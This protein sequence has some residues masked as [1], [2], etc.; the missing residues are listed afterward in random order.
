MDNG[1][2]LTEF[3]SV[4]HPCGESVTIVH[5]ILVLC[6]VASRQSGPHWSQSSCI[7]HL[8]DMKGWPPCAF[9]HGACQSLSLGVM[10]LPHEVLGGGDYLLGIPCHDMAHP[11]NATGPSWKILMQ[12]PVSCAAR[13]RTIA[14]VASQFVVSDTSGIVSTILLE[15]HCG[16]LVDVN[17]LL[18][19]SLRDNLALN[20][21]KGLS[22]VALM[23]ALMIVE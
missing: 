14:V 21:D 20:S 10:L 5:E 19:Y 8:G 15:C 1:R 23:R 4:I 16:I 2:G 17:Y 18:G 13:A 22:N 3:H 9:R 6:V 11:G 7:G 12:Y